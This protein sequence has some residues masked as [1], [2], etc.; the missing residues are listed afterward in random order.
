MSR[1]GKRSGILVRA[2]KMHFGKSRQD[3]GAPRWSS[4]MLLQDVNF[5]NFPSPLIG[6]GGCVE[7]HV[8]AI[9]LDRAAGVASQSVA[10]AL[11][12]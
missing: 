3:A 7:T 9:P 8:D 6:F 12:P 5:Y 2:G 4:K 11:D 10:V 1:A